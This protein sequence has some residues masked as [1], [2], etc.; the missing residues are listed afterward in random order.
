M[1]VAGCFAWVRFRPGLSH[2]PRLRVL[3]RLGSGGEVGRSDI[4][5]RVRGLAAHSS[6]VVNATKK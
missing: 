2:L 5:T 4:P 6:A 1:K 3:A